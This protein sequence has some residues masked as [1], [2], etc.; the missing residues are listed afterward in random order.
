[1]TSNYLRHLFQ[2]NQDFNRLADEIQHIRNYLE[3]QKIRYGDSI[4]FDL[5]W[6]PGLKDAAIPPLL[7]QTFVENAIKHG[8]SFQDS[9]HIQLSIHK[10]ANQQLAISLQDNGPG[11]SSVILQDLAEKKSLVTEDGHHIGLTNARERLDL[12]YPDHYTLQ[13]S[14]G[15]QGGARIQLSLPYEPYKGDTHEYPTR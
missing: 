2:A 10:E 12:L 7:L 6:D 3:I 11:F 9:F 8:F 14:N 13:F 5:D 4:H 15:S 1:M